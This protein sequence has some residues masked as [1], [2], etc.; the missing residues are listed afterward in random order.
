[1]SAIERRSQSDLLPRTTQ[2]SLIQNTKNNNIT[3]TDEWQLQ[4]GRRHIDLQ[5]EWLFPDKA[6]IG[7]SWD[8]IASLQPPVSATDSSK[9]TSKQDGKGPCRLA[10]HR[11]LVSPDALRSYVG[12]QF[13]AD[14][15]CELEGFGIQLVGMLPSLLTKV[16]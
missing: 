3:N 8:L 1:M 14:W 11:R 2:F 7:R 5:R 16:D 15:T 10:V 9:S 12:K 13:D 6:D 4:A